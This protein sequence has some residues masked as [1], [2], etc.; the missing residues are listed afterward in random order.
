MVSGVVGVVVVGAART[1]I[2]SFGGALSS[3]PA[4]TLGAAAI[5]G[6]SLA[7]ISWDLAQ[8]CTLAARGP[9]IASV[10]ASLLTL[11]AMERLVARMYFNLR[12]WQLTLLVAVAC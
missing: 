5:K 11:L 6:L 12:P 9:R 2:G 3:V 8:A 1:A 4:P 10:N 7:S